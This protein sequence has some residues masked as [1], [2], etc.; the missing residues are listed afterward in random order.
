MSVLIKTMTNLP[1]YC[2]DCPCYNGESGYCQA[3][4][5][6]RFSSDYRPFWCPLIET[7]E[8]LEQESFINKPCVARQICHEDKIK[9][10]DKIKAEIEEYM[11]TLKYAISEDE[12]TIKGL[13]DAYAECLEIIDKYRSESEDKG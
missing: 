9:V 11:S 12:L 13:K 2:Y 1:E 4:K 3:D 8:S 7:I 6:H 5:G 10:L